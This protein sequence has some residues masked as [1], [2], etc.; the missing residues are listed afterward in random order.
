[1]NN[2]DLG[3]TCTG[4]K[5]CSVAKLRRAQAKA[6]RAVARF[7]RAAT[8]VIARATKEALHKVDT[9]AFEINIHILCLLS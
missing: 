8:R 3:G 5:K 6:R 1:M 9:F 7:H 4:K 2:F